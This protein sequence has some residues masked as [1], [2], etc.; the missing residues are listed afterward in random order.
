MMART[1]AE[2]GLAP[3]YL[4]LAEDDGAAAGPAERHPHPRRSGLRSI[5][6]RWRRCGRPAS[7]SAARACRWSGWPCWRRSP[8]SRNMIMQTQGHGQPAGRHPG[9]PQ[10][11]GADAGDG[12]HRRRVAATSKRCRLGSSRRQQPQP[13]NT[14]LHPGA[15][16]GAAD[17]G[18]HRER[19]RQGA[20]RPG[21]AAGRRR[22]AAGQGGAGCMDEGV[23]RVGAVRHAGAEPRS[24]SSRR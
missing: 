24:S 11:A 9:I 10:H 2:T 14:D 8:A 22:P 17:R 4:R 20:D 3:L 1:L 21:E 23:G 13:P 18:R 7:T 5:R 16:A 12:E 6:A 15:G 19:P